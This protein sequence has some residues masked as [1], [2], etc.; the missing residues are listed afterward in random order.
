MEQIDAAIQSYKKPESLIYSLLSLKKSL[1]LDGGGYQDFYLDTVWIDDDLSGEDTVKHYTDEAFI[2]AMAPI[3]IKVRVNKKKFRPGRTVLTWPMPP[4]I[5]DFLPKDLKR[6]IKAFLSFGLTTEDDI[7]YQWAINNTKAKKLFILHDDILFNG[8]II[9]KYL[10]TFNSNNNLIA[11]GDFGMCNICPHS[12]TC[13]PEKILNKVYPSPIY[14]KTKRRECTE[15]RLFT[16]D[17]ERL[18]RINECC[19][20]IDLEKN[21]TL[22]SHFGNY[23]DG[24]DVACFWFEEVFHS[25]YD[26]TDPLLSQEE[27]LK[28]YNHPWQGHTGHSVWED[29]GEG[30]YPYDKELINKKLLEDFN[31]KLN[32]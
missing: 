8:N 16:R 3:K 22:K 5:K 31:Y 18:C 7:R 28:Y 1:N 21:K 10:D 24:G 26:F 17:Y 2:K 9:K 23:I 14:P 30:I 12:N 15:L 29:Q 32:Y 20:M 11:V 27:K 4:Y 13:S 19:C 25:K 6:Y